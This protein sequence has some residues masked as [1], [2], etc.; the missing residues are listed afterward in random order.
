MGKT[1]GHIGLEVNL[2]QEILVLIS[3]ALFFVDMNQTTLKSVGNHKERCGS[4]KSKEKEWNQKFPLETN[5]VQTA[6][7]E[8][9]R[10]SLRGIFDREEVYHFLIRSLTPQQATG[11][12]LAIAVQLQLPRELGVYLYLPYKTGASLCRDVSRFFRIL[13]LLLRHACKHFGKERSKNS[14]KGRAMDGKR[15]QSQSADFS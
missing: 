8:P 7:I 14:W 3:Q 15:N 4:H 9:P 10:S 5:V 11:N 13:R 6:K 2:I 1:H 12:A